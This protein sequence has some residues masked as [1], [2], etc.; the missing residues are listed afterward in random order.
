MDTERLHAVAEMQAV[1]RGRNPL[2]AQ[3]ER[4]AR[5]PMGRY[6]RPEELA[7]LICFL[8]SDRAGYITG[9]SFPFDGGQLR[10]T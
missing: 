6:G 5:I 8:A 3:E 10:A 7:D 1:F 9:L 2:L 4:R